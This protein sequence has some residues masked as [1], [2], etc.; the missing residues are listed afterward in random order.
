MW[1]ETPLSASMPVPT[2]P[3]KC[4]EGHTHSPRWQRKRYKSASFHNLPSTESFTVDYEQRDHHQQVPD[5]DGNTDL[6]RYTYRENSAPGLSG[7]NRVWTMA[8]VGVDGR[9]VRLQRQSSTD[10]SMPDYLSTSSSDVSKST[11][12]HRSNGSQDGRETHGMLRTEQATSTPTAKPAMPIS[13][14][15]KVAEHRP[16]VLTYPSKD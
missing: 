3:R 2:Y 14:Q 11:S 9:G 1:L 6:P 13:M 12:Y 16:K 4:V 5:Q 15:G 8:S 7:S 10:T